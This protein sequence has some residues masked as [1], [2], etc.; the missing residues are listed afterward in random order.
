MTLAGYVARYGEKINR[1]GRA[2]QNVR[3]HYD[4]SNRLYEL[5]LDSDMQ[6]SCAYWR[7][8]TDSLEQAQLDKKRH[9]A[10]KLRLEPGMEV[11]D[12]GSGWG[13]LALHLAREHGV[14]VTGVTL[15]KN[16]FETSTRRAAEAGLA[17]RVTF[18]L[19]DYRLETGTYDRIVSVG[20]FEHVGLAS[21]PEFFGHVFRA[22]KP[23]GVALLHTIAKLYG[24]GPAE[25][26]IRTYIFPGGYVPTLSELAP[27]IE[28]SGLLAH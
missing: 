23:D 4:L 8:G 26:W 9:I 22:L 19:L 27:V 20:M 18:K 1:I 12:I 16:Q 15:S 6:Y 17:D 21:Y 24:P 28:T 14:K 10:R 25:E 7:E 11:L 5:F 2:E 13:G 3:H